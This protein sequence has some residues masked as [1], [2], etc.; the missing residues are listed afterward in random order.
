VAFAPDV[1]QHLD[2]IYD[3]AMSPERRGGGLLPAA[4]FILGSVDGDGD[5]DDDPANPDALPRRPSEYW[6]DNCVVCGSFMAP[7]EVAYRHE[8][9][10]TNLIW[11][12]DYPHCE[13]T[14]PHTPEALRNT[15][16][17]V[18]ED[19]ARLILGETAVDLFRFD[20]E[21]LAP[22]A[23]RIGPTPE[24]LA[25]PLAPDELP[26]GQSGAFRLSSTYQ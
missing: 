10:L 16:C 12:S 4:P 1:I 8:V 9:G 19:E 18:P 6:E 20:R 15:F 2:G 25:T 17:T 5:I 21:K 14:W 23:A 24:E 7:Y 22:I 13:G 26:K 3:N 11:G